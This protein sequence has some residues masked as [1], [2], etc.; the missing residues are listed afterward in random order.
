MFLS[1]LRCLKKFVLS[2][3]LINR[4]IIGAST[5]L[6]VR[7]EVSICSCI[8]LSIFCYVSKVIY[9]IK[10]ILILHCW[11]SCK[12]NH[13]RGSH[14]LTLL[15][16][17]DFIL[18]T[19]FIHVID[20]AIQCLVMQNVSGLI[21]QRDLDHYH[22]LPWSPLK[23]QERPTTRSKF[24]RSKQVETPLSSSPRASY[25]ALKIFH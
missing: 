8:K 5:F 2:F 14:I 23:F 16:D 3:F 6:D 1:F 24:S 13:P 12:L 17:L 9:V 21:Q 15:I 11:N 19:Y 25:L 18:S 20:A 22:P 4:I 10:N 7:W